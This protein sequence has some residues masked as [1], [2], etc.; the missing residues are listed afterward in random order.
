[1]VLKGLLEFIP[2]DLMP[3]LLH[4]LEM[5]PPHQGLA[6]KL[7]GCKVGLTFL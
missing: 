3:D 4:G 6:S 1:M 7:Q 2:R 5:F